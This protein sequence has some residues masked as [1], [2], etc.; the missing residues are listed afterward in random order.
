MITIQHT[1]GFLYPF[2]FKENETVD[3][4]LLRF[5]SELGIHF[6]GVGQLQSIHDGGRVMA[7]SEIMMDDRR[8]ELNAWL[9]V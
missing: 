9:S 4:F 6:N 3:E 2:T 8:Y 7:G 5:K 1:G